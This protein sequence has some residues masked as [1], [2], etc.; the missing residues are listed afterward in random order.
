M[1]R[2]LTNL[3]HD[4]ARLEAL[5]LLFMAACAIGIY[6]IDPFAALAWVTSSLVMTGVHHV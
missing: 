3:V 4:P 6:A 5:T 1:K 2:F